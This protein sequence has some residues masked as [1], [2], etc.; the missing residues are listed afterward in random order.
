MVNSG[1]RQTHTI[2]YSRIYHRISVYCICGGNRI[3]YICIVTIFASPANGHARTEMTERDK[4][5]LYEIKESEHDSIE[6]EMMEMPD[7]C[8]RRYN[9]PFVAHLHG[10]YQILYF[11]NGEGCHFVDFKR[12]PVHGNMLFFISPGQ[13]HY[14]DRQIR[15][16]GTILHFNESFL[17]DENSSESVF[18]K[19]NMFNAF[20]TEPFCR[21][22]DAD[23]ERFNLLIRHLRQETANRTLFAHRDYLKYL[24]QLFLIEAQRVGSWNV[25]NLLC[26]NDTA[27]R[28]FIRFRQM[29]ENHY[30]RMHTVKEYAAALN[31]SSKTLTNCV[32]ESSRSTPLKLINDRIVLEAK[33]QLFYS[34]IKVKEIAYLLGFEDPSYFV[35]FFKRQTGSLPAEFREKSQ[36]G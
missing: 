8:N 5:P 36:N 9:N 16:E 3:D 30:T 25:E 20:D 4:L 11:R 35:K 29:L 22:S 10:F 34:D 12:Y 17:S 2:F 13:I 14:F 33:R 21:L 31:V 23:A 6:F 18:L 7:F 28:L 27:N 1:M 19:Y 32:A 24:V 26:P 15:S